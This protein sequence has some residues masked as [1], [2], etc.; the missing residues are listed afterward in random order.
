M[1]NDAFALSP[2]SASASLPSEADYEAISEAFMETSRGRWFLKEYARRNRQADTAMV[3]EAVA[4]IESSIAAQKQQSSGA[5]LRAAQAEA[6]AEALA[7]VRQ[8]VQHTRDESMAAIEA[9]RAD[10]SFAP[11]RR[12][13]RIIREVAWRLREVGYDSR[14]CDILE[15]QADAVEGNLQPAL[16]HH[17]EDVIQQAFAT[18]LARIDALG[19]GDGEAAAAAPAGPATVAENVVSLNTA[20][21]AVPTEP[22][23]RADL[24]ETVAAPPP[25]ANASATPAARSETFQTP[26]SRRL[27]DE[28]AAGTKAALAIETA[29]ADLVPADMPT[30]NRLTTTSTAAAVTAAAAPAAAVA[31]AAK[32]APAAPVAATPAPPV[33]MAPA[34]MAELGSDIFD[35]AADPAGR[36]AVALDPAL[37]ETAGLDDV[38]LDEA[39]LAEA[40]LDEVAL[41][42]AGL[43]AVTAGT[44]TRDTSAQIAGA[45]EPAAL[46]TAE[47]DPAAFDPAELE[48]EAALGEDLAVADEAVAPVAAAASELSLGASLIARGMVATGND[49]LAAFRRMSQAE[50]IAFFS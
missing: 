13:I 29:P 42:A 7:Q 17:M 31:A 35:L 20:K 33:A 12:S 8:A 11:S 47:F 14:I 44:A 48:S 45:L 32:S 25:R 23:P 26:A 41:Q 36:D 24:Q 39:A 21:P 40:V 5:E 1:A 43:E 38:D 15:M 28:A 37:L 19:D 4:R 2:M 6:L 3:L 49:P 30:T 16:T 46:D 22:A 34:A 18:A 50:R 9:F 27:A 10:E